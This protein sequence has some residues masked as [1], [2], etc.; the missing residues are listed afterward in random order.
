MDALFDLVN[1]VYG[2]PAVH[3]IRCIGDSKC[4][5]ECIACSLHIDIRRVRALCRHMEKAGILRS[6]RGTWSF[7][8]NEAAVSLKEILDEMLKNLPKT[9]DT[10]NMKFKCHTCQE[11][12]VLE[13]CLQLFMTGG[14]IMCCNEDMAEVKEEVSCKTTLQ[15]IRNNLVTLINPQE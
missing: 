3:I 12:R 8:K 11:T 9:N 2:L 4:K 1:C 10:M 7:N 13:D 15:D 6:S 5:E 14:T